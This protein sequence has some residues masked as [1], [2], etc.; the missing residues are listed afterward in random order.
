VQSTGTAELP[1]RASMAY[2]PRIARGL[3]YRHRIDRI[4]E[5]KPDWN[6]QP[7]KTILCLELITV[8]PTTRR[9]LDIVVEDE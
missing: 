6:R 3:A 2:L 5:T 7:L 1:Q 9:V 4:T 8:S